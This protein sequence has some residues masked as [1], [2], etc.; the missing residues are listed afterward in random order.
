MIAP[1]IK[2]ALSYVPLPTRTWVPLEQLNL[3]PVPDKNVPIFVRQECAVENGGG[4]Q[5]VQ[6]YR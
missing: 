1:A 5:E 2:V 4:G 6:Q 3:A